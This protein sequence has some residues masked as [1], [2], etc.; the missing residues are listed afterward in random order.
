MTFL[1]ERAVPNRDNFS[2]LFVL[3]LHDPRGDVR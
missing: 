3:A 1:R 2:I